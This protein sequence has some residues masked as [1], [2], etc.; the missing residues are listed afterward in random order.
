MRSNLEEEVEGKD[1]MAQFVL[2]IGFEEMPARFLPGLESS[3][4]D[5]FTQE[6]EEMQI[7]FDR[8]ETAA[9]PRRLVAHIPD[10]NPVQDTIEEVVTGPPKRIA[11]DDQGELTKA[12]LGFANSQ[13]VDPGEIF[14][15]E[16]PKGE[17]LA[18]NKRGGGHAA[19]TLL[20]EVCERVI[21]R[22]PMLKKMRWEKSGFAFGRP[23]R[24][25]LALL[26]S[27]LIQVQCSSLTADRFTRGHRVLGPGPWKVPSAG[28]Y[29]EILRD[30]GQVVL[31]VQDRIATIQKEGD[32]LAAK[33]GGSVVWTE[34]LLNEVA[35]LVEYPR[36]VLGSIGSEYLQLPREVLLTSMESHQKSFGVE[37]AHGNLLPC[38]LC[39]LNIEPRDLDL[40]KRGWER[41]LKA[42]LE[43]AMFFWSADSRATFEQWCQELEKVVFLGPLGS[44]GDK[45]RRMAE[46]GRYL[47]ASVQ[48]DLE[49][50]LVR[51]AE[52][53]KAD[54]VSEMVGEFGDLQG[55]MGSIYAR[56]KGENE[57]VAKAIHEHYLP[58]GPESP[59]PES[60]VGALL[61]IADKVDV[62]TGCFGLDMVPT[63]TQDPYAL[64]RQALGV[65]RII[66]EHGFRLS[67]F[68]L[69]EHSRNHYGQ[70]DWKLDAGTAL[71]NLEEFFSHRLKAYFAGHGY[72]TLIVDAALGAGMDDIWSLSKRLQALERFSRKKEYEAAV[73]TFKRVD[74]IIKKQGDQAGQPLDGFFEPEK[75]VDRQE[76]DLAAKI[77]ELEPKWNQLWAGEQFDELFGL[78]GELR[79]SVDSFFDHVMVMSD[80]PELRLN[81]LNLLKALVNRLTLLADFS[82]LQI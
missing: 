19:R 12:G 42:R 36:P 8:I 10:M 31:D 43:D 13:G 58:T 51:G 39:T 61:A 79:P 53:A 20:P 25:I 35:N 59:V 9:T 46:L 29:F 82:A 74:N 24:W 64:R 55:V 34:S 30:K 6:L 75:F 22:L 47:A 54:L 21:G 69:L 1:T 23:I 32:A 14:I 26:D 77:G 18:V 11:Y 7:G 48:P 49:A 60:Q 76:K 2:E 71:Q 56:Q 15:Q 5:F 66:L 40:V 27:S 78:L 67:L 16:T 33:Q 81:R 68:Q 62:L 38:F 65:I 4:R 44:M 57:A 41:V 73:L 63:G 3:A 72:A 70:I 37:D 50:D 17:Y 80:D 52:L 28:D 45:A